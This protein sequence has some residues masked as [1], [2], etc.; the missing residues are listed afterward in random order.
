M[1]GRFTNVSPAIQHVVDA[2]P[3]ATVQL[4]NWMRTRMLPSPTKFHYTFNLRDL[5][6]VFQGVLKTPRQSVKNS[7]Q[8]L[9]LW[10]HESE[11]VFADKLVNLQV[12]NGPTN[13]YVHLPKL[14]L[15]ISEPSLNP[16]NRTRSCL[17]NN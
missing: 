16:P 12:H 10:R 1:R 9:L 15:T 13:L 3:D 5:S 7:K 4:W 14:P 2:M 17:C 8:V 6:R 11:R